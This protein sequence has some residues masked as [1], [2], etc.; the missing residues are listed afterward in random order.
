M[1]KRSVKLI[2]KIVV[3]IVGVLVIILGVILIPLPGPGFLVIIGGLFILSMEFEW[4]DR[5]YT[6]LKN[7]FDEAIEKV[8]T[9]KEKTKK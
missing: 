1:L 3:G 7:K 8:R 5:Y 9:Q 6:G 4:A 2:R